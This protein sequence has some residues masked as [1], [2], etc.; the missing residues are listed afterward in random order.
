MSPY[1][2]P[3]AG[4]MI[5]CPDCW[6]NFFARE[7]LDGPRDRNGDI[8]AD[9]I[10]QQLAKYQGR[11]VVDENHWGQLEFDTEQDMMFFKLKFA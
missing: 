6:V 5:H 3:L 8:T 9:W 1:T 10:N 11:Y 7:L 4:S 2:I